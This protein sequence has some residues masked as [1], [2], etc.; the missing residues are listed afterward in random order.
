[1]P[2]GRR[3]FRNTCIKPWVKSKLNEIR[4]IVPMEEGGNQNNNDIIINS[5]DIDRELGN[6]ARKIQVEEGSKEEFAFTKSHKDKLE[7]F[8]ND[9]TFVPIREEKLRQGTILIG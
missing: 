3:I 8:M 1:M 4:Q 2:R 5:G 6:I 7:G 9:G